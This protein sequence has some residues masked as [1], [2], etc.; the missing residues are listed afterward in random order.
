MVDLS[1]LIIVAKTDTNGATTIDSSTAEISGRPTTTIT[2]GSRSY[3]ARAP[4]M[5]T[6]MTTA[7]LLETIDK[8]REA[9]ERLDSGELIPAM[10][11]KDL[12]AEVESA[13]SPQDLHAALIDGRVEHGRVHGGFLR[14]CL[15][16]ADYAQLAADLDDEESE[17]DL[18]DLY[19]AAFALLA[20]FE[21]W[22]V[23]RTELMSM[24][25]P[26]PSHTKAK[27][28][29]G[30]KSASGKSAKRTTSR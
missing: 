1:T 19:Q 25:A 8:A 16:E 27:S 21:P 18:P 5:Q 28:A 7:F 6:W 29:S 17:L 20:E 13:A 2:I 26:K 24:A 11:R 3:T 9:Q 12:L 15:S 4:K 10:E 14:R 22:F 30:S 23:Q